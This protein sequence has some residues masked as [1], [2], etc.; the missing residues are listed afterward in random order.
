MP[1]FRTLEISNPAYESADLRFITVKTPNLLGRGDIA[2]YLPPGDGHAALPI[3]TLLH[4][5][6][7]SHWAWAMS[8]GAH[9]TAARLIEKGAIAPIVLAMPSDGLW[10]DGSG[11]LPHSDR[12]FDR[13][14]VDDVPDALIEAGIP[15]DTTSPRCI[16]GLSMGGFG[17]LRLAATYPDKYRA[18]SGL[19]SITDIEQFAQFIEEDPARFGVPASEQNLAD[20]IIPA[21]ESLPLMRFDCGTED[22]LIEPNRALHRALIEAGI[23][24]TYE[25]FPGGHAWEYWTEH[26]VE[27]LTFFDR[28]LRE[29]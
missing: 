8:G 15:V 26:L 11:Y 13:W 27:T 25:E 3:V 24:H 10:G 23:E 22:P 6:Y 29:R 14:I 12:R 5:V 16:A 9:V 19:S 21:D 7:G 2:V 20:V 18:V 4:G 17:A 28:V 1:R